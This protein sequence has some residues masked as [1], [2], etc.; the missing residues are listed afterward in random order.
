MIQ[1]IQSIYLLLAACAMALCFM[2]PVAKYK[3][4]D[5]QV[6]A[7]FSLIKYQSLDGDVQT[8]VASEAVA[9]DEYEQ[10][11]GNVSNIGYK[12]VPVWPMFALAALVIAIAVIAIFLYANRTRQVRVVAVGFL[13][14]VVYVFLVFVWA[15]DAFLKPIK[16]SYADLEWATTY[17]AA[18]WAPVASVVLLFLAQNAIKRDEKKV[19]DAERIR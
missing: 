7:Q 13:L 2:F 17:S 3:T 1:R 15:A 4:P 16:Q 9:T 14:N 19:R 18:A 6:Y 8:D 10:I 5:K 11:G 12:N